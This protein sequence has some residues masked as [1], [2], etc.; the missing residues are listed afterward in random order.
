[1]ASNEQQYDIPRCLGT[2][3]SGD[4]QMENKQSAAHRSDDGGPG[5]EIGGGGNEL[6]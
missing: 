3:D 4:D 1:M 5:I 2:L 6:D